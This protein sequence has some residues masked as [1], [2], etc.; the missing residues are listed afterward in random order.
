MLKSRINKTS[1]QYSHIHV[2]DFLTDYINNIYIKLSVI[3]VTIIDIKFKCILKQVS[4]HKYWNL[5]GIFIKI[6]K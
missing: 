5:R 2:R 3:T 1:N 4:I 6:L